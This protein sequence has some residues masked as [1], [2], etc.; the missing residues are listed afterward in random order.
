MG[1]Y[2]GKFSFPFFSLVQFSLITKGP[3][4]ISAQIKPNPLSGIYTPNT[5]TPASTRTLNPFVQWRRTRSTPSSSPSTAQIQTPSSPLTPGSMQGTDAEEGSVQV[6]VLVA[7][8]SSKSK[9]KPKSKSLSGDEDAETVPEM[10]VGVAHLPYRTSASAAV[11]SS[12][13]DGR[14]D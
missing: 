8:P 11:S 10:V 12:H 1:V 5:D 14:G 3:Q 9:F 7:M 2:Y 6:S 13:L 4:P